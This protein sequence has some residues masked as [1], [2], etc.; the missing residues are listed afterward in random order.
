MV[1]I[2]EVTGLQNGEVATQDI[3]TYRQLGVSSE[4]AAY[5]YHSA[6]GHAPVHLEH[7]RASGEDLPPTIFRPTAQPLQEELY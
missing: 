4:G 1:S 3:F 7:L 6:T 2:T 5:G